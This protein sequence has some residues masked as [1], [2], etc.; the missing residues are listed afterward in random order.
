MVKIRALHIKLFLT[1]TQMG[2]CGKIRKINLILVNISGGGG[3]ADEK[4]Q[5]ITKCTMRYLFGIEI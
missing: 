2:S 5:E 3:G 4:I 1:F